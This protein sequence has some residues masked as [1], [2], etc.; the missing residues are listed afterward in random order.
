M[1]F[2]VSSYFIE[3]ETGVSRKL[4]EPFYSIR[5]KFNLNALCH[6]LT[7]PNMCSRYYYF[8]FFHHSGRR[9]VVELRQIEVPILVFAISV[10]RPQVLRPQ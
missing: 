6:F 3:P 10:R 2:Q 7:R 4:V 1:L 8:Y 9:F 5:V